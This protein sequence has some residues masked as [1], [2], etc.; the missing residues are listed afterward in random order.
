MIDSKFAFK[1]VFW[2]F[3]TLAFLSNF[4]PPAY[5]Q[6]QTTTERECALTKDAEIIWDLSEHQWFCCVPKDEELETCIPITDMKP[7]KK[8]SLKPLTPPGK[9]TIVIPPE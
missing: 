6:T 1:I 9:K 7:L 4:Q 5:S 3:L 8:T 2:L